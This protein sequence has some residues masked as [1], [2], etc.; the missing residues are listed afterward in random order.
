MDILI[1]FILIKKRADRFT[2][3]GKMTKKYVEHDFFSN[4]YNLYNL[5][6][7]TFFFSLFSFV[8]IVGV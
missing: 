7:F 8:F 3:I 4:Y 5:L 1:K 6:Q 2:V